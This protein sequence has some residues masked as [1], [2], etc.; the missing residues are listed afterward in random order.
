[1]QPHVSLIKLCVLLSPLELV[2]FLMQRT[3]MKIKVYSLLQSKAGGQVI[4]Q[5]VYIDLPN[6]YH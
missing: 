1:L 3:R 5:F 2:L 6:Q 4:Q